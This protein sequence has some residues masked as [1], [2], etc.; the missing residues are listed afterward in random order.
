MTWVAGGIIAGAAGV[1]IGCLIAAILV[2][3]WAR[4]RMRELDEERARLQAARE[5]RLPP[6]V[7]AKIEDF[8]EKTDVCPNC[9]GRGRVPKPGYVLVKDPF[10]AAYD[11][12]LA[13]R[14]VPEAIYR[15]MAPPAERQNWEIVQDHTRHIQEEAEGDGK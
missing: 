10:R 3:R 11:R 14:G 9:Y 13:A 6:Q 7:E 2:H 15:A 1:V 4:R 8:M 5:S 12:R